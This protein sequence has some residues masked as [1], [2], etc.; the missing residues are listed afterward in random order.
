MGLLSWLRRTFSSVDPDE[1][2]AE[3]EEFGVPDRGEAEIRRDRY[4]GD[5]SS[6]EGAQ[7]ARDELD[8]LK[9][10]RDPNP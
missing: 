3:R 4:S 5:F 7:A 8:A 10:P 9:P 6:A 2:A 1:E